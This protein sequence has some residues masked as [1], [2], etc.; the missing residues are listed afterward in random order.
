MLVL[1]K[2]ELI[3]R[4]EKLFAGL[5]MGELVRLTLADLVGKGLLF[6]T[7]HKAEFDWVFTVGTFPTG[8]VSDIERLVRNGTGVVFN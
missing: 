7:L 1:H 5:Y 8:F 6:N 3:C 2:Y 4:F